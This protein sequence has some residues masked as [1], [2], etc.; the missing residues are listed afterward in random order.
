MLP[1]PFRQHRQPLFLFCSRR[2]T[3]CLVSPPP[4]ELRCETIQATTSPAPRRPGHAAG[5]ARRNDP[6]YDRWCAPTTLLPPRRPKSRR[7]PPSSDA[8][9]GLVSAPRRARFRAPAARDGAANLLARRK[10]PCPSFR[11]LPFLRAATIFNTL[12]SCSALCTDTRHSVTQQPCNPCARLRR[13]AE[14]RQGGAMPAGG[15]RSSAKTRTQEAARTR[16]QH[17]VVQEG[18]RQLEPRWQRTHPERGC[19]VLMLFS[20]SEM[21]QVATRTPGR[22]FMSKPPAT[23]PPLATLSATRT[24]HK[25]ITHA[26]AHADAHADA[27]AHACTHP[28][29]N[30]MP[31]FA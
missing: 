22:E 3:R 5:D 26:H 8:R 12:L 6:S 27:D 13:W 25:Q 4:S 7:G 31:M 16:S 29:A 17:R 19:V 9:R 15:W 23:N 18:H 11:A 20:I 24:L 1:P 30:Q 21:D 28:T 14:D 2:A 10:H